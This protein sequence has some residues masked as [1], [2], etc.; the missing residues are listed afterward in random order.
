MNKI[1]IVD[2]GGQYA[3]L[4]ARRIREI[5]V[6]SEIQNA[7]EFKLTEDTVG[8]IFSGGPQSVNDADLLTITTNI[9]NIQVPILGI[10]YGHQLIA[11]LS[12]GKVRAG[13]SREF[14]NTALH[15]LNTKSFLFSGTEDMQQVWMSHGDTVCELPPEFE[16]TA[17]T[18]STPIA[19]YQ[20]STGKI[21]GVQF[22]PEVVHSVYGKKILENFVSVCTNQ[23]NWNV[24][25]Y[26]NSIVSEFQSLAA[27]KKL[28]LFISGGVD[29]LVAF[30]LAVKAVGNDNIQALHIDTGFMRLNESEEVMD[31]LQSL[32][33]SNIKLINAADKFIAAVKNVV[34]PEEKRKIIGKL[35]VDVIQSEMRL[36]ESNNHNWMLVQGTIYPDTIESGGT[37]SSGT[38]KTHH[39]RVEE[40]KELMAQNRVIEPLKELYKDEVRE[41][42]T[43][44]G[45]PEHLVWRR[46]FPGPGLAVRLLCSHGEIDTPA[47]IELTSIADIAAT[48]SYPSDILPVKSVGV[49]G[50]FRT[51]NQPVVLWQAPEDTTTWKYLFHCAGSI[52]NSVEGI[53]RVVY[54]P[55]ALDEMPNLLP[56]YITTERIELLKK[57]DSVVQKMTAHIKEIWQLP[58]ISL[59]LFD[60]NGNECFVLRPVCSSDAMTAN[61]Y[62]MDIAL[63]RDIAD[64]IHQIPGT[65]Y[66]F[67]DITTKPPGTIEWE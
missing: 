36:M 27:G 20:N 63:L 58:V 16:I 42:G 40:I 28:L 10:C 50:D 66:V 56:A 3:H 37:K 54:S 5:G 12:G 34:E 57:V 33:F 24:Q 64:A 39:N 60:M 53:N 49:Q 31:F 62:E 18:A 4:I 8:V 41:I 13:V 44:L 22:H 52:I 65:S 67:Y 59:P 35:F 23:R 29:S 6:Y 61:V 21:F 9:E 1:I 51:Y 25:T 55:V 19:A 14:G 48:Y 32:G 26:Y 30:A 7:E 17:T 45:L 2:F 38:I 15:V 43:F 11:K 47:P 46:P